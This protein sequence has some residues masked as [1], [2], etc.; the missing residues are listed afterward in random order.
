[1]DLEIGKMVNKKDKKSLGNMLIFVHEQ[2][3][4]EQHWEDFGNYQRWVK[5]TLNKYTPKRTKFIELTHTPITL[6]VRF[7]GMQTDHTFVTDGKKIN[8]YTI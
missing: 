7:K 6:K 3:L 1:M 8:V 2:W 5:N 4:L